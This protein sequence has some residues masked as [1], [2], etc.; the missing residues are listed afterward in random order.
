MLSED[1]SV[2]VE[3]RCSYDLETG[4]YRGIVY[5][6]TEAFQEQ[7]GEFG[8]VMEVSRYVLEYTFDG[9]STGPIAD[10]RFEPDLDGLEEVDT[11]TNP[12]DFG[13]AGTGGD[14]RGARWVHEEAPAIEATT[15][16]GEAFDLNDLRGKVVLLDFWATWCGPCRAAMPDLARLSEAYADDGLVVIG[17][18]NEGLAM[19]D[20]I[21][22][23]LDDVGLSATQVMDEDNSIN[24]AYGVQAIP[25]TVLIDGEG[26]I[27]AYDV[28]F[29]GEGVWDDRIERVLA[30][31]RL[32]K[33]ELPASIAALP[34]V[35]AEAADTRGAEIGGGR[36]RRIQVGGSE[37]L[38]IHGS[39]DQA[40]LLDPE[41]GRSESIDL[42]ALPDNRFVVGMTPVLP[43]S[44]FETA[45]GWFV[46]TDHN[47]DWVDLE[48]QLIGADGRT[49][50]TNGLGVD[51]DSQ[52]SYTAS[53]V[54]ADLTGDGAQEFAAFVG[55]R[56]GMTG[57]NATYLLVFDAG[58]AVLHRSR[59]EMQHASG[60]ELLRGGRRARLLLLGPMSSAIV[61]LQLGG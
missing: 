11:F 58:G 38:L 12:F 45:P 9:V 61:D 1:D 18:N 56:S 17:I 14:A 46:A 20:E 2:A 43:R 7:M 25:T 35:N 31:E 36:V 48:F 23:F 52:S 42:E 4:L 51:P 26:I 22:S 32:E 5:D 44:D 19:E 8:G 39:M 24:A 10:E 47:V 15:L 55:V 33:P 57:E 3:A 49:R 30:G 29:G 13:G 6:M 54:A 27:Q 40:H 28:G 34:D 60:M 37:R 50:W 16:D 53:L 41:T 59:H 21:R